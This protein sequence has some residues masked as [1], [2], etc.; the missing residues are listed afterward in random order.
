MTLTPNR[1]PLDMR[2]DALAYILRLQRARVSRDNLRGIL[3]RMGIVE[4]GNR[5]RML[6]AI[7]EELKN[8]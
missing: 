2:L 8:G 5:Q 1:A 3:R 6:L 7:Y 4:H